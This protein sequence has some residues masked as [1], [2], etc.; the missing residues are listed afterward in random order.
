MELSPVW[1]WAI[2]GVLLIIVELFTFTF[3]FS[4]LGIGAVITAI[5]TGIGLTPDI[6]SQLVVFAITSILTM[7]LFRKWAKRLFFG[8]AD[9]SPEYTGEKVKVIQAIPAGGEGRIEY[10]GSPWSAYSDSVDTIPEGSTVEIV[11][12]DGVRV[13]IRL[14][15]SH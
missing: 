7:L 15:K 13:K 2:F 12:I 14:T 11:A 1:I 6:N 9:M 8:V 3:I 10:R 5:A 4:F